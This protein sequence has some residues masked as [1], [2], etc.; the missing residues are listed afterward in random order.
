MVVTAERDMQD[1]WMPLQDE[2][3]A[4]SSNSIHR[5]FPDATHGSLLEDKA[6]ATMS[7]QAIRDLV[8]H[9]RQAT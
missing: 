7:S 5:I 4:L 3:A 6:I 2:L 1:G 8:A 9:V